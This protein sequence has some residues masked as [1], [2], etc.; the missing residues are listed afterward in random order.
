MQ[1]FFF[2]FLSGDLMAQDPE[3]TELANLEDAKQMALASAREV[4][5]N[6]IK[7]GSVTPLVA[8]IVT[9][10]SGKEL[11]TIRAKDILPAALK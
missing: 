4:L 2:N 7:S 3:G 6:N 11:L 1:R 9:D 10:E 5:A 8:V